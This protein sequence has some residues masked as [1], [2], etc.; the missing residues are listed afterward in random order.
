MGPAQGDQ[1][2]VQ[3]G[4]VEQR[5][6]V[7][8]TLVYIPLRLFL[9]RFGQV[10]NDPR[11]FKVFS[12]CNPVGDSKPPSYLQRFDGKTFTLEQAKFVHIFCYKLFF[13][14]IQLSLLI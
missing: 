14:P 2:F 8:S 4:Q 3:E 6:D 1:V 5:H 12:I 10:E 13:I 11:H 9:A 7:H